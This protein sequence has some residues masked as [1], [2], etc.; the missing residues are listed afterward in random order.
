MYPA[1]YPAPTG[2]PPCP[3]PALFRMCLPQHC[4]G[5]SDPQREEPAPT[6]SFY[7]QAKYPGP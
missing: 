6:A 3:P 1:M 5:L 2:R 4:R 7:G